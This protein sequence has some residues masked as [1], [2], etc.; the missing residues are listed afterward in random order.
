MPKSLLSSVEKNDS[1]I[2]VDVLSNQL[3]HG[4]QMMQ[5]HPAYE[6]EEAMIAMAASITFWTTIKQCKQVSDGPA[7]V[8]LVSRNARA[9]AP[10]GADHHES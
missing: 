7:W 1:P 5:L 4:L 2:R 6:L 10:S 8:L 3:R 9:L